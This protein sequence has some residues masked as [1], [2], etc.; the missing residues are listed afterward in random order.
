LASPV[1]QGF[2]LGLTLYIH[3]GGEAQAAEI[4]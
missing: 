1:A 4:R 3:A 2:H